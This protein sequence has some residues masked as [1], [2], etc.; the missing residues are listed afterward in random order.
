[1]KRLWIIAAI[2]LSGCATQSLQVT[3]LPYSPDSMALIGPARGE[4]TQDYVL[5]I[6]FSGFNE[7]DSLDA[8][9]KAL[10]P[11]AADALLNPVVQT[12]YFF[13]FPFYCRKRVTATG[14]AIKFNKMPLPGKP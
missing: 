11:N 5:C 12:E 10:K 2:G 13:F 8:I 3:N 14:I 9:G 7:E 1:M 6:P 4:I